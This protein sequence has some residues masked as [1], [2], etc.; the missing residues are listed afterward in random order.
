MRLFPVAYASLLAVLAA[1]AMA[2]GLL[3]FRA[4]GP[5]DAVEAAADRHAYD[6]VGWELRHFPV[7]WLRRLSGLFEAGPSGRE[8]DAVIRRYF[9]LSAE[10]RQLERQPDDTGGRLVAARAE[11]ARLENEVEEALESRLTAFLKEQGLTI[12][13][14]L[15]S[16]I[17][18]LFPP[19]NLEFDSPPKVLA[20][21]P[22]EHIELDRAYLLAPGLD[23]KTVTDIEREAEAIPAAGASQVSAVVLNTGA[24]ATY[25]S[26]IPELASYETV[27][28]DA[29]HEWLHQYLVLFP[30]GRSY[31][32]SSDTRTLNETVANMAGRELASLFLER[33]PSPAPRPAAPRQPPAFDFN[34]EMRALRQ[35]VEELLSA[36]RIDEAERLMNDKRDE[37]ERRG[38]Y[39]R[40]INQAYFA[41]QGSYADTPA[42]IDPIGPKLQELRQRAGSVRE[43]IRLASGLTSEAALDRLL[44][45]GAG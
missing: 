1:A 12:S 36:G 26:V 31:F 40:R 20:V 29:I 3:V 22:R 17:D 5:D 41:F 45:P 10:I 35:R 38:V 25:P 16:E 11:R 18:L 13:P 34:S 24:V 44:A 30:L 33:H 37:F 32:S 23:L 42:S 14:P 4:S 43:F 9:A 6:I 7:E 19:L 21:S 2:G 15:F 28:E 8:Q 39:I 27:I